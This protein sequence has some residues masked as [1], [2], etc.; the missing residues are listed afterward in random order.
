MSPQNSKKDKHFPVFALDNSLRKLFDNPKKHCCNVKPDQVVADLGCG[1]GFYTIDL[2]GSVG[3]SGRV[4]AVDSDEK[5]IRSVER[6]AVRRKYNNIETHITSAGN[7][8]FIEKGLVDFVLAEG[9]LCS[10]A[11]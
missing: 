10:M 9:L 11:P 7:L 5:A 1:P 3:P 4:Y 2:A 6:K 8:S